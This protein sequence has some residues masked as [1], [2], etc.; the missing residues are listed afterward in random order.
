MFHEGDGGTQ[1]RG[2]V[3]T[4]AA[5]AATPCLHERWRH[6]RFR[7]TG[8]K[9]VRTLSAD[10]S[11]DLMHAFHQSDGTLPSRWTGHASKFS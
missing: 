2:L 8:A 9:A 7:H 3:V 11:F 4:P 1:T 10:L 5:C 6:E